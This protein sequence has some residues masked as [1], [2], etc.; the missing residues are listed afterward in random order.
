MLLFQIIFFILIFNI[1]LFFIIYIFFYINT[2]VFFSELKEIRNY[3]NVKKIKDISEIENFLWKKKEFLENH[4]KQWKDI[5][6]FDYKYYDELLNLE[7][8]FAKKIKRKNKKR[9]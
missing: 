6:S 5:I 1:I 7:L 8:E 4:K 3:S 2:E 9:K